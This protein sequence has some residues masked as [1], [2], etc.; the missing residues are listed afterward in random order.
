MLAILKYKLLYKMQEILERDIEEL[1]EQVFH[2]FRHRTHRKDTLT[3]FK[4]LSFITGIAMMMLSV[5]LR[6]LK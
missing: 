2:L 3:R 6:I 4:E 1:Q 5:L